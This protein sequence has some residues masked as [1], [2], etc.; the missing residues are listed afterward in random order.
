MAKSHI[1]IADNAV[2]QLRNKLIKAAGYAKVV[3][4]VFYADL[5]VFPSGSFN[6]INC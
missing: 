2:S 3:A 6:A 1:V 4:W 5:K